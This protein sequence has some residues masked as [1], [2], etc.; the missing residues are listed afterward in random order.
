MRSILIGWSSKEPVVAPP[1][2]QQ[3]A[4]SFRRSGLRFA[5]LLECGLLPLDAAALGGGCNS[6]ADLLS[7]CGSDTEARSGW[8]VAGLPFSPAGK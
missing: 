3:S 6:P 8:T 2:R 4:R 5:G 1:D 7:N